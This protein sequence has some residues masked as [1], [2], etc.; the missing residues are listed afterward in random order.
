MSIETIATAMVRVLQKEDETE[1]RMLYIQSF[2]VTQNKVLKSLERVMGQS[3]Q[4]ENVDSDEY[5]REARVRLDRGDP[6][7]QED[8]VSALSLVDVNWEGR[9]ILPICSW[10]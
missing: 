9:M 8:L 10:V 7:A 5:M 2:R 3:W 6:G 1:N 4:A